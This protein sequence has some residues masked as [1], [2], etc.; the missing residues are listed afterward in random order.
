[1]Y[2]Y[3][4]C[5][6]ACLFVSDKRKTLNQTSPTFFEATYI[7]RMNARNYKNLTLKTLDFR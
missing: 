5:L 1:M 3:F 7:I 2:I 4:A 6:Y